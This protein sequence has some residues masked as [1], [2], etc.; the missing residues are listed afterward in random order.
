[1]DFTRLRRGAYSSA[2]PPPGWTPSSAPRIIPLCTPCRQQE[3]EEWVC[4]FEM[5]EG[6]A[7][8]KKFRSSKSVEHHGLAYRGLRDPR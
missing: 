5:E 4:G 7:C 8:L 1:M 2:I 3:P 6:V